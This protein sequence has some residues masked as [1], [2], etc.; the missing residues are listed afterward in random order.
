MPQ[1]LN[2]RKKP[3]EKVTHKKSGQ[4]VKSV[5]KAEPTAPQI[6]WEAPSFYFSPQKRY[7]ALV[8]I[9]LAISGGAIL[10]LRHDTLTAI[11]LLL[12]SLVLIL[13]SNKRPEISKVIVNQNGIAIGDRLYYYK[14]LKSFWIHYNPGEIKELS[15]ESRKWYMLYVKVLIEKENP[16]IIRS[17][18]INFLPE[19]EHENSLIDIISRKIGL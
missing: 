15:L 14:E 8:V 10:F 17:F 18:L 2:L 13:Y 16:L 11:F 3:E 4:P 9:A 12:A 7:F 1:V 6:S 5:K 19:K